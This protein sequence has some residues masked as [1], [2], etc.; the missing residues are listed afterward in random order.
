MSLPCRTSLTRSR[1]TV[2]AARRVH[3][4]GAARGAGEFRYCGDGSVDLR[5]GV[6]VVRGE[7][8]E[9]VNAALFGVER[10]VLGHGGAD[11]DAGSAESGCDVFRAVA[12]DLR[13]DD[14]A[15]VR[16]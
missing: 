11:V 14:G 5:L 10:V 4:L 6:V 8:D 3:R 15:A 16:A 12:G 2:H 1:S 7:A 9:R 13:G